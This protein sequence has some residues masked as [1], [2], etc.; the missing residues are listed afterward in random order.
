MEKE[1]LEQDMKKLKENIELIKKCDEVY[2]ELLKAQ[3]I[4]K[5]SEK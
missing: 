1:N 2:K 3:E 5:R 4:E